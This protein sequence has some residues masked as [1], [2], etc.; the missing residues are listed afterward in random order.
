MDW[1]EFIEGPVDVEYPLA[2][3]GVNGGEDPAESEVA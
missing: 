3:A 1:L 2:F